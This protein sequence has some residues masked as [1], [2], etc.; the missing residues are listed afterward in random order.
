[1]YKRVGFSGGLT[2]G[3]GAYFTVGG[4]ISWRQSEPAWIHHRV[5][6]RNNL[7]GTQGGS[8]ELSF[9][10]PLIYSSHLGESSLTN[11]KRQPIILSPLSFP[12]IF[13]HSSS[14]YH[15]IRH[16]LLLTSFAIFSF[17]SYSTYSHFYSVS[18]KHYK[19]YKVTHSPTSLT[20]IPEPQ[21]RS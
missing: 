1:M 9:Q 19:V 10:N 11:P 14:Y 3:V 12:R 4:P 7:R 5:T 21:I 20:S 2:E 16:F 6:P 15:N 18:L 8:L 17:F 13:S